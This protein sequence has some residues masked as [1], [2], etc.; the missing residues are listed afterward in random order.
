MMTDTKLIGTKL[1]RFR[2]EKSM[3][4][5]QL[6]DESGISAG[7]IS[8]IERGEVNPSV[9]NIQRLCFALNITANELMVDAGEVEKINN[10]Q[11]DKTYVVRKD[12]RLPIYG[13]SDSMD[14]ESVFDGMAGFKVNVMTLRGGMNEKSYTVHSYDEFGIVA[15]GNLG[16]E[17][18]GENYALEEGD[19]I[20]IRANT[21]HIVTNL[22]AEDCVSY[23]IEICD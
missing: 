13:I 9:K 21:K 2:K 22:S 5:Q 10:D 23:W 4:L 20:M 16:M 19:C 18:E 1:K 17:V 3:K 6:A 7:Y 11:K 14:F 15:R 12:Q 8:K